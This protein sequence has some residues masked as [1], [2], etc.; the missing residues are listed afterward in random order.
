MLGRFFIASSYLTLK[1]FLSHAVDG[2]AL[3]MSSGMS[4][5]WIL[6]G[7]VCVGIGFLILVLINNMGVL[8]RLLRALRHDANTYCVATDFWFDFKWKILRIITFTNDF[9]KNAQR[10]LAP[11]ESTACMPCDV[12]R[13]IAQRAPIKTDSKRFFVSIAVVIKTSSSSSW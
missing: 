7:N 2:D 12:T 4:T 8:W 11:G 6:L 3:Y 10:V 5:W 9:S 1:T 13:V